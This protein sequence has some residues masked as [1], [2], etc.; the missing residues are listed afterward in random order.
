MDAVLEIDA[1]PPEERERARAAAAQFAREKFDLGPVADKWRALLQEKLE[2]DA[3]DAE[4]AVG[5]DGGLKVEGADAEAPF[6]L[7]YT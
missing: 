4:A 7:D 3:P 1:Q 6:L 2:P 5:A